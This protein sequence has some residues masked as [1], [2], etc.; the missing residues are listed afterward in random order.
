MTAGPEIFTERRHPETP[1]AGDVRDA[2]D[3]D[4]G[5]LLVEA[6][7]AVP[8]DA[9]RSERRK[10]YDTRERSMSNIGHPFADELSEQ[11]RLSLLEFLKTL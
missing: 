4:K 7:E 8:E 2:Y 6:H 1:R 3:H 11:Q 10:F 5:G 9:P